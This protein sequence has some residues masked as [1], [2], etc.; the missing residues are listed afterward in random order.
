M[1]GGCL[2]G[3]DD[4]LTS[5][6][7]RTDDPTAPAIA[8]VTVTVDRSPVVTVDGLADVVTGRPADA[9]TPFHLCSA[10]KALTAVGV[11]RLA[12]DGLLDLD[13]D[14]RSV[15]DVEVAAGLP[16]PTL[17]QLLSHH[18]GVV[19]APGSFE[20]SPRR[21]PSTSDVVAGRT[22]HHDGP[23]RVTTPPGE[24][25]AYSDAGFCL[26]ERAVEVVTGEAFADA[27]HW[28]VVEPLG[29]TAT[30]FWSGERTASA[31]RTAT[32]TRVAASAS[33]GHHADG[34]R[35]EGTRV[36]YAGPAASG[37][38]STPDDV[39]VLLADLL[40]AWRG[41]DGATLLDPGSA[42]QMLD[43]RDGTGVGLGVFVGGEAGARR[44]M[45]QGWGVGFQAKAL[46]DLSAGRAGAVL[47]AQDPGV[48]Q[49]ESVVGRTVRDLVLGA[50]AS[51][52]R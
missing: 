49:E 48:P 3:V 20:P 39:A 24:A 5:S 13:T 31:G 40:R 15:V 47:L 18:G 50:A 30:T 22:R 11:L 2:L 43:D 7:T 6:R 44:V 34:R 26:V 45:T 38:W 32:L 9:T 27:M 36:H 29:L 12:R 28:T 33:A 23:V 21:A 46:A 51:A 37:L 8:T 19:D 4:A 35:V 52:G 41:D 25:F 16:G 17:R 10:A 42:A 14:V 1:G